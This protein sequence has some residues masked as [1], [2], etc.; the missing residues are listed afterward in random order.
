[1]VKIIDRYIGK[2]VLFSTV[3]AVFVLSVVLVL[4]NVFQKLI[5][6]LDRDQIDNA[7]GVIARAWQS[8]RQII[9]LGNGGSSLT[10]LH[11]VNDWN[12]SIYL[13]TGVPFRG[14][15]LVDNMGL[16]MAYANDVSFED[17]FVEQLKNLL[18]G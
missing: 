5:S 7:I 1:M 14:R 17:V 3:F 10:A 18:P 9:T 12:K 2:Q 11:F 16:I 8:G 6:E 4:G 15:S 13:A